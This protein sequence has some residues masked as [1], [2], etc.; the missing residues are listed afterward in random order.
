MS[1]YSRSFSLTVAAA[2]VAAAFS[3]VSASA[4]DIIDQEISGQQQTFTSGTSNVQNS[5]LSND[6]YVIFSNGSASVNVVGGNTISSSGTQS[7]AIFANSSSTIKIS[8]QNTITVDGT[9]STLVHGNA[10]SHISVDGNNAFTL[11]GSGSAFYMSG[12]STLDING[13]NTISSDGSAFYQNGSGAL[14]FEQGS[15]TIVTDAST[16]ILAK[17]VTIEDGAMVDIQSSK[18][19]IRLNNSS[20]I[21]TVKGDLNVS[22]SGTALLVNDNTPEGSSLVIDGGHVT[23]TAT[24][25]GKAIADYNTQK[26]H[27]LM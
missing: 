13:T 8:G 14:T 5:T 7:Y 1:T 2:L 23:L 20:T 24:D 6:G 18:T 26:T 19:G 25:N 22:S 12:K 15:Q 27:K 16:G 17:N 10:S 21:F 11:T 9:Q 3:C 4:R